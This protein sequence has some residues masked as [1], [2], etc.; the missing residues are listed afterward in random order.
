MQLLFLEHNFHDSTPPISLSNV[1]YKI[2]SKV[3]TNK[4]KLILPDIIS[5]SHSVFISRCLNSDNCLAASEI[6]YAMK[7]KN[8]GWNGVMA[9]KLD[10]NKAYDRI[11]WSLLKQMMRR[12]GFAKEWMN[13]IM[14][15]VT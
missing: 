10:I 15:C 9:L 11:E 13:W 1:I 5:P 3:L 4:L 12:L 8:S 14:M 7:K 6:A 2:C